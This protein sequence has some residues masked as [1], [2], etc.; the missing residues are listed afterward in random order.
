M[1]IDYSAAPIALKQ[2]GGL[3][4]VLG[5]ENSL[6][7]QNSTV[8]I[9]GG[10]MK[11]TEASCCAITASGTLAI[12]RTSQLIGALYIA[13]CAFTMTGGTIE[14]KQG[15]TLG[16]LVLFKDMRSVNI[17]GGEIKNPYE[18]DTVT[19]FI[20]DSSTNA[21]N[22][23]GTAKI[24]QAN[25]SQP[26][27][28]ATGMTVNMSGG[29]VGGYVEVAN[30]AF[31]MTGGS[32]TATGTN[33]AVSVSGTGRA[34]LSG[35]SVTHASQ[36]AVSSSGTNVNALTIGGS[37]AIN[38]NVTASA[39][40]F[41]MTGGAVNGT[42]YITNDTYTITGATI[43]RMEVAGSSVVTLG[44]GAKVDVSADSGATSAVLLSNSS[45]LIVNGGS[46][47]APTG[48][49]AIS[50]NGLSHQVSLEVKG[51]TVRGV[52]AIQYSS[53][54]PSVRLSGGTLW[55]TAGD[56]AMYIAYN[57][58]VVVEG[59]AQ[60]YGDVNTEGT[61][62]TMTG[63]T[64]T[65][66]ES[67]YDSALRIGSTSAISGGT[68]NGS[69]RFVGGTHTITGA[70]ISQLEVA[71]SAVV[72][73]GAGAKVDANVIPGEKVSVYLRDYGKLI[74]DGGTVIGPS[75]PFD[76]NSISNWVDIG[77]TS[78]TSVEIRSGY[79]KGMI[80]LY[81]SNASPALRI[82]GGT[83]E[84][85]D[86][87]LAIHFERSG[88]IVIEGT[89][90]VTGNLFA[91]GT[92]L[93][94]SGGTIT[95]NSYRNDNGFHSVLIING[96]NVTITGGTIRNPNPTSS[97]SFHIIGYNSTL[98]FFGGVLDQRNSGYS[99]VLAEGGTFNG[100]GGTIKQAGNGESSAVSGYGTIDTDG[101][102][103]IYE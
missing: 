21:M 91:L 42:L 60:V 5:K 56:S 85:Y 89:A 65:V 102:Q 46:G 53:A 81:Q 96:G 30:N 20:N 38:G 80:G 23:G 78:N 45:K 98:N 57:G 39:G 92:P 77:T 95:G 61:P 49:M 7:I 29:S 58:G 43:L 55:G 33:P 54:N 50:S 19:M 31:T 36:P 59:S 66:I 25:T 90:A 34:A 63:G 73:L 69:L 67:V 82:S 100:A 3:I 86:D 94:I 88:G 97:G 14:Q 72:T 48:V 26:A 1:D 2:T 35:G 101:C 83:V 4:H 93:T 84:A 51:G 22:F 32:V 6:N 9:F 16:Y 18:N 17:T 99:A 47:I 11:A 52:V 103:I 13:D 74:V 79:V 62:L 10:T 15:C 27:V 76:A 68:I 37:A 8:E 75:S 28:N 24:T 44:T 87:F 64:I 12:K 40:G 70:T 71:G 41:G